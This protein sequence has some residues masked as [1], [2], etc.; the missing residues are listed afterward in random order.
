MI[1]FLPGRSMTQDPNRTLPWKRST[2][3]KSGPGC[4]DAAGAGEIANVGQAFQPDAR[5]TGSISDNCHDLEERPRPEA[6]S[7][8]SLHLLCGCRPRM[9]HR[10]L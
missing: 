2:I 8:S 4:D 10:L 3:G 7:S 6:S 1:S 9:D 5:A